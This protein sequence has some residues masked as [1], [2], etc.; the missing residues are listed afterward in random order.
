RARRGAIDFIGQNDVGKNRAVAEFEL[1]RFGIVDADPEDVAGKKVAGELD[2]LESAMKGFGEGLRE[3]GFADAGN[4]F[5]Q[6]VAA[7]QQR[8]QGK[9]NH[10]FLAEDGARNGALQLRHDLR[11]GRRHWLKTLTLPVTNRCWDARAVG[12]NATPSTIRRAARL[13]VTR[14]M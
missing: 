8:D 1:A 4:V 11:G 7:R 2:A 12:A 3:R 14:Y 10:I 5:D 9:L 13:G 6:Q